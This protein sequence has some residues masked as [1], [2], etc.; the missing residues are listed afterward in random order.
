MLHLNLFRII[1]TEV[2]YFCDFIRGMALSLLLV[3]EGGNIEIATGEDTHFVVQSD[4]L[5]SCWLLGN[6][7][8]GIYWGFIH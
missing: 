2:R 6:H 4:V 5:G 1:L 3:I 7:C 8:A